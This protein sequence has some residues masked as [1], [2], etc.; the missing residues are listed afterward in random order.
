M[1]SDLKNIQEQSSIPENSAKHNAV[2]SFFSQ[3][4]APIRSSDP[5][6]RRAGGNIIRFFGVLLVLT[7]IARGTSGVT[8]ARVDI[9][10]PSPGE[11]VEA[12]KD[13]AVVSAK[14][15]LDITLPKGITILEMMVGTGQRVNA[16]DKIA[17]LDVDEIQEKLSRESAQLEKQYLDLEKLMRKEPV[18]KTGLEAARRNLQRAQEDLNT[19]TTQAEAERYEAQRILSAARS[20]EETKRM[21]W[22]NA[23]EEE[24]AAAEQQYRAAQSETE[25]AQSALSA[26]QNK[27]TESQ[28]NANRRVEDAKTLVKQAEQEYN[29]SAQQASDTAAENKTSAVS[30]RLDIDIQEKLVDELKTLL[31]NEGVVYSEIEGVVT[32]ALQEGRV[33]GEEPL[34]S[35]VNNERGFE[36]RLQMHKSHAEKL[37]VGD[38]CEVATGGGSMYYHPTVTGT[39]SGISSPDE[40]EFVT[41]TIHLPQGDWVMGQTVDIRIVQSKDMYDFCLPVSAL[42]SNNSGYFIFTVEQQSTV[43]GVENTVVQVPV[44]LIASDNNLAAVEGPVGRESCVISGSNKSVVAGD[45][46]RV[47]TT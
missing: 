14:N 29:K 2:V 9:T 28:Q 22:E 39:L 31:T 32:A 20:Y 24:K 42:H 40:R 6:Q 35:F 11:I 37:S 8:L 38:E 17:Q 5:K 27:A 30:L 7:L 21:E 41:V 4:L 3:M 16:G 18:D 19:T 12:V 33:S 15:T 34:V 23:G 43:L 25:R 13:K 26:A 45:H 47:G 1:S 10:T 46:V 44:D 36:A